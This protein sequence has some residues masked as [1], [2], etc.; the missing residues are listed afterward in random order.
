MSDEEEE[1]SKAEQSKA[2]QSEA[3]GDREAPLCHLT[4]NQLTPRGASPL[5]SLQLSTRTIHL[6]SMTCPYSVW[7]SSTT[8]THCP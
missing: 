6:T 5:D 3:S 2:K 7:C 4:A 1:E 8:S